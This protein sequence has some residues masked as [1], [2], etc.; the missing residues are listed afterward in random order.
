MPTFQ[1]ILAIDHDEYATATYRA[2]FPDVEVVCGDVCGAPLPACDI[3]IGGPPCQPFSAAGK[4]KGG[5]DIRDGIPDFV[6]AVKRTRP[7][8]FLMENVRGLLQKKHAGYFNGIIAEMKRCGYVVQ[9]AMLDAVDFGVPQFRKRVWVWGIK[10]SAYRDGVRYVWPVQTHCWPARAGLLIGVTVGQALRITNIMGGGYNPPKGMS[11]LRTERDITNEPSTTIS[12]ANGNAI[13]HHL[14]DHGYADPESP[15]PTIKAGGNTD[16]HGHLGGACP[17]YVPYRWSE[18]MHTKHPP[19]SPAPTVQ[20]K[21]F[22]GGAEGL[23]AIEATLQKPS[24]TI[25]AGGTATGGEEPITH[26]KRQG[27]VRR[28]TPEECL[29]LQSGPDDFQWPEKI[30]KTAKYRIVGNGQASYFVHQ[31]AQAMHAA[32]PI[33]RTVVD[34][35][36]GGGLGACGFHGRY[37][38]NDAT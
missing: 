38:C 15:C 29:R 17:P 3:I 7:R 12:V 9:Y 13:P 30:T 24:N 32:D 31:M 27:Y 11:H 35:F 28:L 34:L 8:M 10:A 25:S 36:C 16:R 37:W 19:A 6:D 1:T 5:E 22:K 21:W 20:A 33:S 4:Q 2:N 18:A 23:L 14:L 26:M